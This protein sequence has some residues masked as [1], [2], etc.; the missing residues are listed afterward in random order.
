[1]PRSSGGLY[2]LPAGSIVQDGVDDILASQHN[3]P[4]QDLAADANTARPVVAGGTGATNAA[5]ALVN[6]GLTA[7]AAE[8]NLLDGVTAT[9][10][11]I[12]HIDGVTA[13][14]QTQLDN[15]QPADGTLI[16][17]AA[18]DASAGV[19]AQ[20]GA[21]TFAK[22]TLSGTA[23]QI[24]VTNGDGAA[25]NPTIAAVVASQAEAEA[26]T[27]ATKLMTPQRAAQAIAA[28][29]S[30]TFLAEVATASGS[31]PADFDIPSTAKE[32]VVMFL[33][34][35]TASSTDLL[36]RLGTASAFEATGYNQRS[37]AS[38]VGSA[39]GTTGFAVN[40]GFSGPYRGAMT[41][42]RIADL[43]WAQSHSVAVSTTNNVAS[44]GGGD[45][46]LADVLTRVRVLPQSGNW[47]GGSVAVGYRI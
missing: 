24:T 27:D 15:K 42:W 5:G 37:A 19:L 8:I 29:A 3:T 12:N 9:T 13:P 28:Q 31:T 18:L 20:T 35:A 44:G 22:R 34:A 26:G 10:A 38:S 16:A 14:I 47:S 2:S 23:N 7:T 6:L 4:L 33:G 1:M 25:G 21:D 40:G 43:K 46:T 30:W 11:E 45:K 36:V 41:L 17:L 32:I 39:G